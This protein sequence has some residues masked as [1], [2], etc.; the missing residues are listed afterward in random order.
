[1]LRQRTINEF[2]CF[3]QQNK[4]QAVAVPAPVQAAVA[5][6]VIA[7][8]APNRFKTTFRAVYKCQW[9]LKFEKDGVNLSSIRH[10]Q[11]PFRHNDCRPLLELS[12]EPVR[13]DA[14][15][16][17]PGFEELHHMDMFICHLINWGRW[18]CHWGLQ[19]YF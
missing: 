7:L 11:V 1:M 8:V 5:P 14:I 13:F 15:E 9:D 2:N 17:L 12:T 3:K 16:N 4:Q 6:P 18:I 19:K 10:Y